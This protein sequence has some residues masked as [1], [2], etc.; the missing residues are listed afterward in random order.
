M[1]CGENIRATALCFPPKKPDGGLA[2][3]D[4]LIVAR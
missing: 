1:M 3:R 2:V 4:L